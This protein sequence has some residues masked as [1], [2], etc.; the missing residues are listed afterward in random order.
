MK[1]TQNGGEAMGGKVEETKAEG[2]TKFRI[3][4]YEKIM[5]F[6]L[7]DEKMVQKVAEK[8]KRFYIQLKKK[9]K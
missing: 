9:L 8:L 5:I 1:K 3:N 4:F 7:N 6:F 2:L